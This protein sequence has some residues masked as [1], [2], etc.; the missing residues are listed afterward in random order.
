MWIN[1]EYF[2]S[3]FILNS[4]ADYVQIKNNLNTLLY[5]TEVKIT[6]NYA[7]L[8]QH[9][10]KKLD[11]FM[12]CIIIMV[13]FVINRDFVEILLLYLIICVNIF[14]ILYIM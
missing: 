9:L 14:V 12:L 4:H 13:I 1:L 5:V 6:I 8:K 2:L 7:W 11:K 10:K 3:G